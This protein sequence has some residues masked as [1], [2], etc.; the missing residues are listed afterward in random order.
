MCDMR[1][2]MDW[3][4]YER[5]I[6]DQFRAYYPA[7]RITPNAKLIG[8]FSKVERQIDHSFKCSQHLWVGIGS[9]N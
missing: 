3:K 6:T 8:R 4:K 1:D 9:L 2:D 5:E 7:S